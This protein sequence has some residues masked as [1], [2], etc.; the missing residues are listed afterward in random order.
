MSITGVESSTS[1]ASSSRVPDTWSSESSPATCKPT[2]LGRTGERS[3]KTPLAS[4]A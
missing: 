4:T 2:G 1:I 3:A